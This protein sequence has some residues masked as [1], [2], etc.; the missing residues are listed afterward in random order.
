MNSPGPRWGGSTEA[1]ATTAGMRRRHVTKS[2]HQSGVEGPK[3]GDD[4]SFSRAIQKF[5]VY[6]RVDDDLQVKTETGAA[7]TIGSWILALLLVCGEIASYLRGA[8]STERLLVDYTMGQ[9]LRINADIVSIRAVR[10][11]HQVY[12]T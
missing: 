5:D 9:R 2:T 10:A 11:L 4:S 12:T 8:P 1:M 7:V 6:A 3:A